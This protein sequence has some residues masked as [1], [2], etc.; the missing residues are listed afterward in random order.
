M[1]SE[2]LQLHIL[3]RHAER[4]QQDW[5]GSA[6]RKLE[7]KFQT[8]VQRNA[9]LVETE[10]GEVGKLNAAALR[11]WSRI[12]LPSLGLEER[13]QALDEVLT[14]V[15]NMGASGGKYSKVIRRFEKWLSRC[16]EILDERER[17]EEYDTDE[18]VF[19]EGMDKA[20][21]DDCLV[22]GRK[23]EMWRDKLNYLGLPE[24]DSSLA[25]IL[26]GCRS[27]VHGMLLELSVMARI[28]GDA[29]TMELAWIKRMNDT[30][31][32]EENMPA[33]GAVWRTR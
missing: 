9:N 29:V 17:G 8:V 21:K 24:E 18:P 3:H 12:G 22:L 28:E 27:L 5:K 6:R 2:L 30:T 13:I 7:A 26:R 1:Q 10:V 32:D 33:V 31:G 16:Q 4:V 19:I 23:L 14:G 20:W 15:W 11:D 25:S